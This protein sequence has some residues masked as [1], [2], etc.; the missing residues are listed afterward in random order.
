MV[1]STFTDISQIVDSCLYT[2]FDRNQVINKQ[3]LSL[4]CIYL[5]QST[6]G[7]G[8]TFFRSIPFFFSHCYE[9]KSICKCVYVLIAIPN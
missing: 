8:L 3:A 5:S 7:L 4:K 9:Y 1:R 6:L 2:I